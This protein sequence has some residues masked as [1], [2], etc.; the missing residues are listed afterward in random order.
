[1]EW[2]IVVALVAVAPII[3]LPVAFVTYLDVG[4]VYSAV[5]EIRK[6]KAAAKGAV[7]EVTS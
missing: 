4:G 5:K 6:Q 3:L 1:M 2:Q 7:E